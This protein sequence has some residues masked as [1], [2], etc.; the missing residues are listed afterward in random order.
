MAKM[1]N[2]MIE[3][4]DMLL[5]GFYPVDIVKRTGATME[6]VLDVEEN[7]YQMSSPY[8]IGVDYD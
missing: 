7:L 3:I 5:A 2:L 8:N 6:M 1:K 4:E